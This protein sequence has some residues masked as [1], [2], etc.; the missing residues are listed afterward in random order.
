MLAQYAENGKVDK[1]VSHIRGE[2][3]DLYADIDIIRGRLDDLYESERDLDELSRREQPDLI[4]INA[5]SARVSALESILGF[6]NSLDNG[7]A[8]G[9]IP[10][11]ALTK[12]N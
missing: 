1:I 5:L 10:A 7:K 3:A 9:A 6:V 2:I 11:R 12:K 8:I 4:S